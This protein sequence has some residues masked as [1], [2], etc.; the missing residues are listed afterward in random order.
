MELRH[1]DAQFMNV[2]VQRFHEFRR[3]KL[4][5]TL[6]TFTS[7][8]DFSDSFFGAA[9]GEPFEDETMNFIDQVGASRN[10][11]IFFELCINKLHGAPISL[12]KKDKSL[13]KTYWYIVTIMLLNLL[14]LCFLH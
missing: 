12:P 9:L 5:D 8:C 14:D 4:Q 3:T 2:F 7:S 11:N 13:Y 1:E 6:I 10:R